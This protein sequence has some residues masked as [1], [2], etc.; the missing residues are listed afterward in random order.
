MDTA[1]ASDFS[2]APAVILFIQ[3]FL[4]QN[5]LMPEAA[6]DS[7]VV[8]YDAAL[9]PVARRHV[10]LAT[11]LVTWGAVPPRAGVPLAIRHDGSFHGPVRGVWG[12]IQAIM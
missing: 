7:E 3:H 6:V 10:V 9:W 5:A 11:G 4:D 8:L 1:G 12:A 2:D